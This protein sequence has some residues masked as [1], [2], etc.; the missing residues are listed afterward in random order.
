MLLKEI[1]AGRACRF[2]FQGSIH[3]LMATV[4]LR[5]A[6]LDTLDRNAETQPPNGQ[7]A[8]IKRP[9]GEA[10]GTPLSE[11]MACGRPRSLNN[12]SEACK[13]ALFLDGLHGF[14]EQEKAAG[15]VGN[16]QWITIPFISQHELTLIVGAPQSIGNASLRQRRTFGFSAGM[17]LSSHE[18]MAT[19]NGVDGAA[20]RNANIVGQFAQQPFPQFARAPSGLLAP[21]RDDHGFH[22]CGEL[23]GVALGS[24]RPVG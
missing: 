3:A 11:R 18:S 19:Q 9:L 8:Q 17:S 13:R 2:D 4:L 16:S 5:T 22:L 14:A 12:R 7:F 6:R 20:G 23:V 10:N 24:A 21:Q 15:M 1:R